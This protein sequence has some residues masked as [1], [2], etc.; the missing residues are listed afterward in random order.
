[1]AFTGPDTRLL[2]HIVTGM[3]HS[4]R[5]RLSEALVEF[6]AAEL[7]RSQMEGSHALASQV[8]GW[9][10]ATQARLDMTGEARAALEA[11]DDGRASSGEVRNAR[12]AISLADGDPA[13]ARGRK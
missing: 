10:L 9:L 11:L 2:L 4:G 8:T 13:A 5:G 3:L 1:V 6:R 12:A 7:L